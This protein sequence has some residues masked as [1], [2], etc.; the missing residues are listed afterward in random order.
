LIRA[1]L[2]LLVAFASTVLLAPLGLLAYPFS[3]SGEFAFKLTRIW[4]RA[5]LAA[6]GVRPRIEGAPHAIPGGPV[7][8]VSNHVSALD[9]PI[10]FAVLPRSF[11]IVYKSSLQYVPLLGQFL[12]AA[13]H[14]AIDRS[15]AFH[16]KKSLDKAAARI[17]GG[18]SVA[19]FPEG[20]R[21]GTGEVRGFKRGSFRLAVASGAP[22]VPVTLIGVER[23]VQP[24]RILKGEMVVRFDAA[25]ETGSALPSDAD[26]SALAARVERVVADNLEGTKAR[27]GGTAGR[28][29]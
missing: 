6:A 27:S 1:T 13:R 25:I 23:R 4:A 11:R 22:V 19:L 10:L 24:P 8:F 5:I 14:V 20:T 9:I 17:R 12:K 18:L 2:A 16:A 29:A 28:V 21:S 3:P 15:R 7:V 26:G